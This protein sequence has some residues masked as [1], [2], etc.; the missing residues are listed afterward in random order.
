MSPDIASGGFPCT[1]FSRLREQ[2][3]ETPGR[4]LP[5]NH[6]DFPTLFEELP[7]YLSSRRPSSWWAEEVEGV[8]RTDCRT[9]ET[10]LYQL[11]VACENLKYSVQVVIIDHAV[12]IAVPRKRIYILG[13]S[14]EAGGAKAAKWAAERVVQVIQFREQQGPG[15]DVWKV[16]Q[17]H[18]Q[19]LSWIMDSKALSPPQNTLTPISKCENAPGGPD[20]IC[21]F[22]LYF[23]QGI[24]RHCIVV[25][26]AKTCAHVLFCVIEVARNVTRDIF[27][28]L[29]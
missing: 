2:S 15:A 4:G 12:W 11:V 16:V 23:G 19:E 21:L 22:Y 13:F 18:D 17:S 26:V 5:H 6:D 10:Y 27:L 1:P 20:I 25:E 29:K 7:K 3:G 8:D 9:G 14:E 28:Y 24:K